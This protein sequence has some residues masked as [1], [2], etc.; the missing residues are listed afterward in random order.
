MDLTWHLLL[1]AHQKCTLTGSL[2]QK[3]VALFTQI[4]RKY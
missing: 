3:I 1:Y 2:S 4:F